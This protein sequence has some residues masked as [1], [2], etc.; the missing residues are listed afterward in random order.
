LLDL[1]IFSDPV[2]TGKDALE[3]LVARPYA[4]IVLDLAISDVAATQVLEFVAGLTAARPVVIAIASG[5]NLRKLDT[6]VVQIVVRHPIRLSSLVD[7]VESC[8]RQA[9]GTQSPVKSSGPAK[10]NGDRVPDA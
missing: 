7:L 6:E 1:D 3:H 4:V 5:E 9:A 2:S 10:K 8:C